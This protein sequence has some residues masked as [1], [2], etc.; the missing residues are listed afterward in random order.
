MLASPPRPLISRNEMQ[1]HG[2]KG[3]MKIYIGEKLKN[4]LNIHLSWQV[5]HSCDV[6]FDML[7]ELATCFHEL[8][9]LHRQAARPGM[10][11]KLNNILRSLF[12]KFVFSTSE[13]AIT[14]SCSHCLSACFLA[15]RNEKGDLHNEACMQSETSAYRKN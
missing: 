4:D 15:P 7:C 9:R 10:N 8:A 12:N 13:N 1:H 3:L 5:H 14:I 6:I 2:T 11:V